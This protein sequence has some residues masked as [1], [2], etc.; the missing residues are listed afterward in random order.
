M[1][2][3]L[4]ANRFFWIRGLFW[5]ML[6]SLLVAVYS[7]VVRREEQA[8][9]DFIRR[10]WTL[11]V[12][13]YSKKNAPLS[14]E[15]LNN[16]TTDAH[17]Q[18]WIGTDAALS[19]VTPAGKWSTLLVNG[20]G[21]HVQSVAIDRFDRTWV[22]SFEGLYVLDP[23]GGWTTYD[24][25]STTFYETY[26]SRAI[27][28]DRFDR[29][30]VANDDGLRMFLPDGTKSFYT[31]QNSGLP[32]EY[33]TTLAKDAQGNI[34]IGTRTQGIV[35]FDT[36][37]RWNRNAVGVSV[38]VPFDN[39]VTALFVDRQNRLW[40][41]TE[42]GKLGV[43]SPDGTWKSY[44]VYRRGL[45]ADPAYDDPEINAL[46]MDQQGRLWIGTSDGLFAL[47]SNGNWLAFTQANSAFY[48]DYVK[49]LTVDLNNRLWIAS[50]HEVIVLDLNQPLPRTVSNEWIQRRKTL[51]TPGAVA[52]STWEVLLAPLEFFE[53]HRL[54]VLK[55]VYSVLLVMIPIAI[56]GFYW[57]YNLKNRQLLKASAWTF[58]IGCAGILAFW[59]LSIL[60]ALLYID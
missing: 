59:I 51:L 55:T 15:Y 19:V 49:A 46:A 8:Y 10:E 47:E 41:G 33:I 21:R 29:V 50:F 53:R 27:L 42:K 2:A 26:S 6:I 4:P 18:V 5:L 44:S 13:T 7:E 17:G 43:L 22:G 25:K 60:L 1:P 36:N 45:E 32:D 48:P 30:W 14:G 28:I 31:E 11:H 24:E 12:T 39:W 20:R 23:N 52:K 3:E 9:N 56:A 16:L 57:G 37:G 58:S 40:V 34:W 38:Q 54:V 35:K